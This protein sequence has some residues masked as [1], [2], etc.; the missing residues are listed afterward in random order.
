MA[1]FPTVDFSPYQWQIMD[2][3][4]INKWNGMQSSLDTLQ[5]NIATF[6]DAVEQEQ[7]AAIQA[8]ET[9]RDAEVIPAKNA[10]AAS[11]QAASQDATATAADRTAVASDRAL[12]DQQ[13]T[14]VDA[15]AQSASQAATATANDRQAVAADRMHVD[16]QKAAVDNAALAAAGSADDAQQA[17]TS[18]EA[19]YGDLAA[20]NDAKTAAQQAST[21]AGSEKALAVTARQGAEQAR[22]EAQA[23]AQQAGNLID[24]QMA[25]ANTV[26]S[27]EKVDLELSGKADS[28][29]THSAS[30]I[31]SGTL[32]GSR[33]PNASST[34]TGGVR[35]RLNGTTAYITNNGSNA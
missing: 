26:W 31:T 2:S 20:V 24:D 23:A 8:V 10:A 25:A 1:T 6:G 22:D 7:A 19:L 4:Y 14:A 28:S 21:A 13:K 34:V 18:A 15:D 9:I 27:S 17:K 32:S 3:D 30:D 16:Q 29:H 33:L 35:V 11:A 5:A 12:V